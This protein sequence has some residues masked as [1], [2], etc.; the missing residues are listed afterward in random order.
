[1][2][3]SKSFNWEPKCS[4]MRAENLG[5]W[6]WN[7]TRTTADGAIATSKSNTR[8]RKCQWTLPAEK[9]KLFV[10]VIFSTH[11]I[12]YLLLVCRTP[13]GTTKQK[14]RVH[15]PCPHFSDTHFRAWLAQSATANFQFKPAGN[16]RAF[17]L[18]LLFADQTSNWYQDS[19]KSSTVSHAFLR[20]RIVYFKTI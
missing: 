11:L 19:S 6:F 7:L 16:R 15:G 18:R 13:L 10:I 12:S 17:S 2:I 8:R 20:Y 14:F 1:M 9:I 3:A 5:I 4:T